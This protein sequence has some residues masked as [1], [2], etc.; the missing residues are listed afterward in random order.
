M[1]EKS[2]LFISYAHA[3][4]EQQD[5]DWVVQEIEKAGA[6]VEYDDRVVII[7]QRLWPQ[8]EARIL[9][10]DTNGWGILLTPQSL[11]S[12]ACI[13]ELEYARLRALTQRD[14][15]FPLI[16]MVHGI[17]AADVPPAI[18]ARLY[19]SLKDPNWA[20][21]VVAGLNQKVLR[22]ESEE[23]GQFRWRIHRHYL[24]DPELFAV[25]AHPRFSTL[26]HF[27]IITPMPKPHVMGLGAPDGGIVAGAAFDVLT[28]EGIEFHGEL[29]YVDSMRGPLDPSNSAY[30][31]FHGRI[32]SWVAVGATRGQ[33]ALP[34]KV[35]IFKIEQGIVL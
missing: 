16:G 5:F 21:R 26:H 29:C 6:D 27:A 25:E 15:Q 30:A 1:Q 33:G 7:G 12:Q 35:E 11:Q 3:D 17:A 18:R 23:L 4:N 32:P 20:E 19:V 14:W 9:S 22:R 34:E 8:I 13:E 24:G 31:V 2:R 28:W 10:P